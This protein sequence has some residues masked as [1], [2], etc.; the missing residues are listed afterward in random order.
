MALQLALERPDISHCYSL[1]PTLHSMALVP[2]GKRLLPLLN[3]VART[4]ASSLAGVISIFYYLIPSMVEVAM[5]I[6]TGYSLVMMRILLERFLKY[7][8]VCNVLDLAGSELALVKKPN[9]VLISFA[10]SLLGAPLYDMREPVKV[11]LV[12]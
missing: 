10:Y 2:Q 12:L 9:A 11:Y 5:H 1:F 7:G 3:P 6:M 8:V 4:A